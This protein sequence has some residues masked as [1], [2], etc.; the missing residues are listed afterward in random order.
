MTRIRL[1]IGAILAILLPFAVVSADISDLMTP[2]D[3]M[4]R[5]PKKQRKGGA[6]SRLFSTSSSEQAVRAK[7][8][9]EQA[10][11][12]KA[13]AEQAARE[14]AAAEQAARD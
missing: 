1:T 6:L 5:K 12:D 4:L 7:A 2:D 14:K 10:A 3:V 11:R 8:A 13:A 9:A